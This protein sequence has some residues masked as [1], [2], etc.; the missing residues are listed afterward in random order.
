L[1]DLTP[2]LRDITK[3]VAAVQGPGKDEVQRAYEQRFA[4]SRG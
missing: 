3:G 2:G 4:G 1:G